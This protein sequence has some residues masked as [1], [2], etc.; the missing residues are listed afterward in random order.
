MI[1]IARSLRH[2]QTNI[3][4]V[5]ESTLDVDE[6]TVGETT[7]IRSNYTAF[8]SQREKNYSQLP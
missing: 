5:G 2:S 8:S 4:Y 6:Q 7:I 3:L 1:V